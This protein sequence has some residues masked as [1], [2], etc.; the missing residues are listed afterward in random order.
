MACVQ[1]INHQK[2]SDPALQECLRELFYHICHFK[3]QQVVLRISTS[4]NDIADFISRNHNKS[5]I[6]NFFVAKGLHNVEAIDIPDT[7]FNFV[8][9]W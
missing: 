3:F 4:E 5:D 6:D 8:G 9:D 7:M 2:P 1:T